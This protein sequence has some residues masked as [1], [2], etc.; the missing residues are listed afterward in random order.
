MV[1]RHLNRMDGDSREDGMAAAQIITLLTD[2]GT[3]D[4]YAGI[5]KGILLA[6]APDAR[7][8][9]LVHAAEFGSLH[10]TGYLLASAFGYFPAG[11]VHL[12]LTDPSSAPDRRIIVAELAGHPGRS[13]PYRLPRE[14][15]H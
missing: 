3:T 4:A 8:V 12:V 15:C 2:L 9:D 13:G 7:M 1:R 10:A 6:R 5:V 14:P 11:T